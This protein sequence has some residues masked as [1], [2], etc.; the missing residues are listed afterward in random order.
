MIL[1]P[2]DKG[3]KMGERRRVN[4]VVGHHHHVGAEGGFN[5]VGRVSISCDTQ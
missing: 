5:N 3:R 1:H 2:Q 4:F